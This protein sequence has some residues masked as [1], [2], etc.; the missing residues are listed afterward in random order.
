[1]YRAK[2]NIWDIESTDNFEKV[3]NYIDSKRIKIGKIKKSY[4]DIKEVLK[5]YVEITKTYREQ[6]VSIALKLFPN[7]DTVEGKL[8]QAIQGILLFNSESLES[9]TNQIQ[10][11][12]KNF[13]ADKISNS[14]GLDE[15]SKMYQIN[16]SKV[17]NLYC[18][19]IS[20]YELYEKY[21]IH[22]ELDILNDNNDNKEKNYNENGEKK[23]SNNEYN[24][25]FEKEKLKLNIK[26]IEANQKKDNKE[27]LEK[28]KSVKDINSIDKIEQQNEKKV[29]RLFDN[30]E[31]LFKAEKEYVDFVAETNIFIKKLIE[32]GWNE[33]R[34]LKKDFYNNC[35]KFVDKLIECI[36]IQKKKYENQNKVI[37]EL[38][39][40]INKENLE[41]CY[42]ESS[43]YSLHSLSIYM[44]HKTSQKG[45][46]EEMKQKG[47]FDNEIYK[48]L[49][50]ENIGN[51]INEMQKNGVAV[52]KE[53]LSNYEREKNIDF[54]D[55]NIGFLFNQ[56]TKLPDEKKN[57]LIELFKEDVDYILFFLQ[58]LNNDRAKGGQ[59]LNEEAYNQIGEIFK[60]INN[61]ILDKNDFEC[62]K[63]ISILSMT[64]FRFNG[65]KKIYVYEYIKD[66]PFFQNFEFWE[67]YLETLI[68]SDVNNTIY[69]TNHKSKEKP[70][71]KEKKFKLGLATF[72]NILTVV[73]NMIDF[74]IQKE[75]VEKFVGFAKN[76]YEFSEEQM[77][78]INYIVL[79][80]EVKNDKKTES[81]NNKET[82]KDE[83]KDNKKDTN[84]KEN[85]IKDNKSK[86]K[87]FENEKREVES[88][89]D[90]NKD[91]ENKDDEK[92]DDNKD[93]ENKDEENK[94]DLNKDNENKDDEKKD[95]EKKDEEN[96]DEENK[97][98]EKKD[99]E[100]KDDEKKDDE[101]KY[102]DEKKIEEDNKESKEFEEKNKDDEIKEI[103]E[104]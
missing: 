36:D 70:D 5:L 55:K 9:F 6:L 26:E 23:E 79:L 32:F 76:K 104:E 15:F 16:Y 62:F 80:Y 87:L 84:N 14:G 27:K 19:Y 51:I 3:C 54:I 49:N 90:L 78:Q 18:N 61:I 64:Y 39:H 88:K 102:I 10:L 24:N 85:E 31:N 25:Q 73:N 103:K 43:K 8:I 75:F 4:E 33:E 35:K 29:E 58:K 46:I 98:D 45:N 93:D 21:L 101:N 86:E 97:D 56:K 83:I 37:S 42:L 82:N 74:G 59:I 12:L 28:K 100:N 47:E 53:D 69:I 22:K 60:L 44:N 66:H 30:H 81:N 94:D 99:E 13:K 40:I 41:N 95:D 34:I 17:L 71:E 65:N 77:E 1:M 20:Q 7:S 2:T 68:N 48:N 72:S 91:N 50:I 57:K 67:K 52:K 38:D 11:I 96:K 89:D 63:Y 92:K